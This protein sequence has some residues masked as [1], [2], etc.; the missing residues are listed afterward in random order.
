MPAVLSL[1]KMSAKA[2]SGVFIVAAKRTPFGAFGGRLSKL[3]PTGTYS[4]T[5]KFCVSE[6]MNL[7]LLATVFFNRFTLTELIQYGKLYQ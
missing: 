3:S 6:Q 2:A 7:E 4:V 5:D 1:A